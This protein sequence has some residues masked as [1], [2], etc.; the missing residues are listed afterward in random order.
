MLLCSYS[1]TFS[2]TL[3]SQ[4]SPTKAYSLNTFDIE[5]KTSLNHPAKK[6]LNHGQDFIDISQFEPVL[7]AEIP[8]NLLL[9]LDSAPNI[10]YGHLTFRMELV[11]PML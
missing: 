6:E 7:S 8:M 5:Q 9:D 3:F 1:M 10:R 2:L 11:I 4:E